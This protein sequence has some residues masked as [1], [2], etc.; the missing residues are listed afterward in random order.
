MPKAKKTVSEISNEIYELLAPLKDDERARILT[1]VCA[2]LGDARPAG[3]G[4]GGSGGGRG[5]GDAGGGDG[6]GGG[7]AGTDQELARRGA[8]AYFQHKKPK[9]KNEEFAVAAR[10]HE[11]TTN[12]PTTTKAEFQR[13]IA[14]EARGSFHSRN[15]GRDI[16]NARK[17]KFFNSGGSDKGGYTLH[18]I[19]LDYVDALPDREAAKV[20]KKGAKKKP[21]RRS[22]AKGKAA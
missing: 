9:G 16:D 15:F 7:G 12:S 4:G 1:S 17:A 8:R 6:G 3:S 18:A 5:G 2:L 19:G 21:A 11:L 14:D 10:F 13:I 22:K 20:I